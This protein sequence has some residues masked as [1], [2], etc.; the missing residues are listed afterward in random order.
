MQSASRSSVWAITCYFPFDDPVGDKRRLRTYRGFRERL[1]VPLLAVELSLDGRFDLDRDD[2]EELVQVRGGATLWQKERLLNLA[3]E[4][5]PS[6]CEVVLW[7]DCDVVL[8]GDDWPGHVSELLESNR[9]VQPFSTMRYLSE[10]EPPRDLA[11]ASISETRHS[12]AALRQTGLLP[13]ESFAARGYSNR[14]GYS[15]G[16]AWAARR[17]LLERHGF[18]DGMILG[19]G[20]KAIFSA[21]CGRQ[22][23]FV[24]AYCGG[25]RHGRHYLRWADPFAA[26]V[27]G[28]IGCLDGDAYHLFHGDLS[29]RGY[30]SRYEGFDQFG[31]DPA[32]DVTK[33]AAGAWDWNSDKPAMHD[34][35]RTAFERRR[36]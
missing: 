15:P 31:F 5:L 14:L 35:V 17:D 2:A 22:E 12:V 8:A 16:L 18:Y 7:T 3:L 33:N 6:E 23:Q 1:R 25:E 28:R 4:A 10:G 24:G 27:Q 9:V 19:S 21:A 20:D 36:V 32:L 34:F 11:Q 29:N 30:S 13:E 26:D